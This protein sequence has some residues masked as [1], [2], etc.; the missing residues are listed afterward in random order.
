MDPVRVGGYQ[1]PGSVMSQ[2][3]GRFT[4]TLR[5]GQ[6][7]IESVLTLDVTRAGVAA[8]ALFDQV[9]AGQSEIC[10]LA[11]GY[12]SSRV[13]ELRVLDLPFAIDDRAAAL[14][15]LDGQTGQLLSDAVERETGLR[16]L[17]FLDNGFRH[18]SNRWRPL[19]TPADCLGLRVRTLDSADY[20]ATLQALGFEAVTTD[21]RDLRRVVASGEVDA[22]ENPLTNLLQFELWPFHPHVSLTGHLFG[23][24]LLV[25]NGA[26]FDRLGPA[27]Q[28]RVNEAALAATLL[29]RRLAAAEDASSLLALASHGIAILGA[30]ALDR[31]A[32]KSVCA[33]IARR[34]AD[35]L[36][37]QLLANYPQAL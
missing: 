3:L 11:S 35:G 19:R 31:L 13:A 34:I 1:G 17:A 8:R 6:G 23:V 9:E 25:C 22:Q 32:M 10:Y 5:E 36:A 21:V 27:A 26:W 28:G 18:I 33:P 24:G 14:H 4:E 30:E 7:G 12:L 29:Q 15:A 2:A 37:P 20:R 16:V